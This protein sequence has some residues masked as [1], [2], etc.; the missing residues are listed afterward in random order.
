MEGSLRWQ[1]RRKREV[2][3]ALSS[4][5]STEKEGSRSVLLKVGT[6]TA[7]EMMH[8]RSISPLEVDQGATENR[9]EADLFQRQQD[10]LRH[11]R[12]HGGKWR[13]ETATPSER[14]VV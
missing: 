14:C 1:L 13:D 7:A 11:R 12:S 8:S 2:D 10:G 3:A 5:G 9:G 6:A 4:K